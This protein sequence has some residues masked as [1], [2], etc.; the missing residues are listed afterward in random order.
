M[1]MKK[2]VVEFVQNDDL[3]GVEDKTEA[4]QT[5]I[6]IKVF[7]M[8]RIL[9]WSLSIILNSRDSYSSEGEKGKC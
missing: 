7:P 4:K 5:K 9:V 1:I 2:G 8:W 3:N 6:S